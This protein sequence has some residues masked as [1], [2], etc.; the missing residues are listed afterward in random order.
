MTPAPLDHALG[1]IQSNRLVEARQALNTILQKEPSHT[2]ALHLLATVEAQEGH[3]DQALALFDH[4]LQLVPGSGPM[5]MDRGNVL[6]MQDRVLEA[7]EAYLRAMRL[8]P[9]R[10]ETY[11]NLGQAE[12][13]LG[14]VPAAIK[15]FEM[16]V[17]VQPNFVDAW[18]GLGDAHFESGD[19]ESAIRAYARTLALKPLHIEALLNRGTAL[20]NLT[21]YVEA[22]GHF[23]RILSL[24]PEHAEAHARRG[25]ALIQT[26]QHAKGLESIDRALSI[27]PGNTDWLTW[28]GHALQET[29]RHEDA[30]SAYEKAIDVFPD[31]PFALEGMSAVFFSLHRYEESL[32]CADRALQLN[33]NLT[34]SLINRGNARR[35]LRDYDGALADF[36]RALD[37]DPNFASAH[38]NRS[39][40]LL[41]IGRWLEAWPQYEWRWKYPQ[42]PDPRTQPQGLPRWDGSSSIA[43]KKIVL[44]H[45][46]GLGDTLQF[47]RFAAEIAKRGAEVWLWLPQ[48][49]VRVLQHVSGVTGIVNQN[50]PGELK[51][52][53][54]YCPLMSLPG[55]LGTTPESIPSAHEPYLSVET[56]LIES[57]RARLGARRHALRVG[58]MWHGFQNPHL[59][60]RSITLA[61]LEPL[62]SLPCDFVSLQK[63]LE[64]RHL[65]EASRRGIAHFGTEQQDFAD[66]AAMIKNCDL[67][68]TID[69]SI[70]HLA[71][72]MGAE[73]WIVLPYSADWRWMEDT[74]ACIWYPSARLFR[75]PALGDWHSPISQLAEELKKRLS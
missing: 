14:D 10:A 64:L 59:P 28:K 56:T 35:Q 13:R 66:A 9:S 19:Y 72:A 53:D 32:A 17:K 36:E 3:L 61:T 23:D 41:K 40:V 18:F 7:K 43:G 50:N 55:I 1:L 29:S 8:N 25:S 71:G 63:D 16:A 46:Q 21:R 70:A 60:D 48:P 5:H 39:M 42:A 74:Q 30:L 73:T 54:L 2:G 15:H 47:V 22:I 24:V 4:A 33:P 34:S 12:R 67:V 31:N 65:E 58:V 62:L 20:M 45:E 37:I 57:W 51:R 27:A 6:L 75:Q 49:L 69:T 11:S 26:K 68:V 44:S 38:V 52:F